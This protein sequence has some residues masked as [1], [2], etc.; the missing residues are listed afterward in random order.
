VEKRSFDPADVAQA[1]VATLRRRLPGDA[2]IKLTAPPTLPAAAGDPERVRQVLVNLLENAYKYSPG[3]GHVDVAVAQA[4]G[5]VRFTVR[6]QGLGIPRGEQERIFQKFYR[7]DAGMS[8][9]VGGSG[10]GLFIARELVSLMDGRLWVESDPGIGSTFSFELPL[11]E[12]AL[13]LGAT[14]A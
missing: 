5:H 7:L 1:A 9:G 14:G 12:P 10:L 4:D 2:L 8:R 6:D 13:A 11:A 3:G